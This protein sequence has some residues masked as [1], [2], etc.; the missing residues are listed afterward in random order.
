[1]FVLFWALS[2]LC[3]PDMAQMVCF[4]MSDFQKMGVWAHSHRQ[5]WLSLGNSTLVKEP[6]FN[7]QLINWA[8]SGYVWATEVQNL[9]LLPVQQIK[10]GKSLLFINLNVQTRLLILKFKI[11]C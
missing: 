8:E 3:D 5:N 2:V 11:K 7:I 4:E 6:E 10:T 1:M 9:E